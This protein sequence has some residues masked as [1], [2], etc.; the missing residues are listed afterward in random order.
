MKVISVL[1]SGPK[2]LPFSHRIVLYFIH[3]HFDTHKERPRRPLPIRIPQLS[4]SSTSK[5]IKMRGNAQIDMKWQGVRFNEMLGCWACWVLFFL[6][7]IAV[8]IKPSL[9]CLTVIQGVY[10]RHYYSTLCVTADANVQNQITYIY[11]YMYICRHVNWMG[12]KGTSGTMR[13]SGKS[14]RP[15]GRQFHYF[16]NPLFIYGF[17]R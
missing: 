6:T 12:Q 1:F 8:S 10:I 13:V 7:R 4:S 2:S 15:R 17:R 11:I 9:A 14:E 3:L 5:N 16:W